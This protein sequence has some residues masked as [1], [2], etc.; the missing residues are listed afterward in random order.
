MH[1]YYYFH[2]RH[3]SLMGCVKKGIK[4]LQRYSKSLEGGRLCFCLVICLFCFSF[5]FKLLLLLNCS[6]S[7][8]SY[9]TIISAK[10]IRKPQ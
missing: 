6:F 7:F 4:S 5:L 3:K 2:V 8:V 1:Y 9:S 10:I